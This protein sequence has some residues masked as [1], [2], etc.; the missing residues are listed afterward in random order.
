LAQRNPE[1]GWPRVGGGIEGEVRPRVVLL[2]CFMNLFN[3]T[4]TSLK[5]N[6]IFSLRTEYTFE[7]CKS[8]ISI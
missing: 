4:K 2:I 3:E 8:Q 7:Q 6:I 5:K 1:D